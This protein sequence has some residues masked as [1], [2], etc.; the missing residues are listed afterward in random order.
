M[1]AGGE[2]G[3]REARLTEQLARFLAE[4]RWQDVPQNIRR[5]AKRAIL[6]IAGCVLAGREDPAVELLRKTFPQEDALVDAAAATA[7]DYDDTHLRTVIHATPPLA[8]AL[9][10][11]ARKRNVSGP[12]LL[13]AFILGMETSCRLG[14]AVTPGHYERG[15]HITSTCGVFGAAAAAGKVLGLNKNQ[16][17]DAMGI[18]ATQSSGLVEVLGSM[19]RVLNAGFAAR[20]GLAAA[21]LAA[22]GFQG[23]ARPLEGLRGFLNVFGGSNDAHQITDRLGEH[24]EMTQVAYKPYPC[25]VVL[26]A[27]VDGCLESRERIRNAEEIV[28]SLHPLAVERADRPEPRNAIEAKLSAHHAVAVAALRGR[29]GLAEFSDAA[30]ADPALQAFRRRVRVVPDDQLDKMA[31]VITAGET[32]IRAPASRP[33]DDARLEAKLRELA[34]P[35]AD[36][37]LRFVDSLE[38]TGS[39]SLPGS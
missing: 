3:G 9:F 29:A 22:E 36:A 33:M 8:G 34:G 12:D 15:W 17:V 23:P 6:N 16:F 14:N 30:A 38:S 11:L 18:A 10:S 20:N 27:L 35:R 2:A 19:A 39:V 32:V 5:E 24:W 31:A 1:G 4:A 7:H 28:V 37:W 25:G 26:H 21:L 13:H